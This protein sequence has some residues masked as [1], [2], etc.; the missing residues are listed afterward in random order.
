M[1]GKGQRPRL[2]LRSAVPLG[3][4]DMETPGLHDCSVS[5]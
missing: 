3:D 2:G 5:F 4:L 1:L